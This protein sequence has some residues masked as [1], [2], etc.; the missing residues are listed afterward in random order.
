MNERDE[1]ALNPWISIWTKPRATIQQVI[2]TDPIRLVVL[3]AALQGI[4]ST[5]DR[6]STRSLGD[7]HE[8]STI[9]LIA[10]TIG[11]LA[12]L[13]SLYIGGALVRWTGKWIGG[14]GSS[15]TVRA[16]LAWSGVPLIW[17]LPIWIPELLLFGDELFTSETPRMDS[18]GTLLFSYLGFTLVELVIAIW[19]FVV[20]LKCV[21]QVQGFTAWK[22]LGNL[23]LAVLV[24]IVPILIIAFAMA[25][26]S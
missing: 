16:A 3:L 21:G 6:A 20:L 22:A 14:I 5:L 9:L 15:A 25:G 8:L 26:L 18:S 2:D 13:L 23:L 12:G 19:T 4:S 10:V 24:I 1:K 17:T 11:P 7:K